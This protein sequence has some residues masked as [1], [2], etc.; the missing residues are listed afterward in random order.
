MFLV[1]C[2]YIFGY[3]GRGR[4]FHFVTSINVR[5]KARW[6]NVHLRPRHFSVLW[7]FFAVKGKSKVFPLNAPRMIFLEIHVCWRHRQ[8]VIEV[9]KNALRIVWKGLG[10]HLA[11]CMLQVFTE[12]IGHCSIHVLL[13]I[14]RFYHWCVTW[15]WGVAMAEP[16]W[17]THQR[18][19]MLDQARLLLWI[20]IHLARVITR[21]KFVN[22]L[23]VR[24]WEVGGMC[25][26]SEHYVSFGVERHICG[27]PGRYKSWSCSE[28]VHRIWWW[29]DDRRLVC[30]LKRA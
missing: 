4:R 2:E 18:F 23:P 21:P 3:V 28:R 16:R 11:V 30:V 5:I 9:G 1:V 20:V 15:G 14:C 10:W 24:L 6:L 19:S 27:W 13:L 8:F 17:P 29:L 7:I 22:H 25:L 26:G 12:V